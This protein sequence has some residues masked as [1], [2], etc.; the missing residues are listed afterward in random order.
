MTPLLGRANHDVVDSSDSI[1]RERTIIGQNG[2]HLEFVGGKAR[3]FEMSGSLGFD[4][5]N[6]VGDGR[7][8]VDGGTR[9]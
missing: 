7:R 8:L 2:R 4:V 9:G 5:Y 3:Y 1:I 6:S